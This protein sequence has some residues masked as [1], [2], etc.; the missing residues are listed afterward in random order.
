[1]AVGHA[2]SPLVPRQLQWKTAIM[3]YFHCK[4]ARGTAL[5]RHKSDIMAY[6]TKRASVNRE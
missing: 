2:R 3:A 6:S 1:M 5:D 4:K